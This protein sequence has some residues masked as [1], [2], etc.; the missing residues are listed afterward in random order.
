MTSDTGENFPVRGPRKQPGWA[1]ITAARI[2]GRVLKVSAMQSG[3]VRKTGE[4]KTKQKKTKTLC[5]A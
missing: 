3:W 4:T 2:G 1:L 5:K